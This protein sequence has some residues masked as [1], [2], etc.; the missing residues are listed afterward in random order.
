MNNDKSR[1]SAGGTST[2]STDDGDDDDHLFRRA[3]ADARPLKKDFVEPVRKRIP[4][5]ARFS[6]RDERAVLEE[7]LDPSVAATEAGSGDTLSFCRAPV[8]RRTFRKL[9][10]GKFSVQSEL[11]LHGMTVT[12]ARDALTS[13]IDSSLARGLSCVRVIH[14]KGRGSGLAGPVLKGKVDV[15]LRRWEPILAFVS[16]QPV[17]GG[18]GALYVLLKTS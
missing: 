18:S 11:D 15:W 9:A 17:D 7:S 10:R 13:F 2:D 5:K 8:G 12:E 14:G 4:A 1:R 6:R 16:A 3:V